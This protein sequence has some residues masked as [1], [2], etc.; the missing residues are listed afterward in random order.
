[1]TNLKIRLSAGVCLLAL[2]LSGCK[3][4][5]ATRIQ[6]NGSGMLRTEV[7]FSAEERRNLEEQNPGD[8]FCNTS[9]AAAGT[10]VTEEQRDGETWCVTEARFADLDELARFYAQRPGVQVNRLEIR[11]GRLYYDV[12]IDTSSDTSSFAGFESIVWTVSLPGQPARHN[13]DQADGATLTW[14]V[15]PRS[16]VVNLHAESPAE[17]ASAGMWLWLALLAAGGLAAAGLWLK[18]RAWRRGRGRAGR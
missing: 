2:L 18:Q 8:D 5:A 17:A 15:A 3:F 4:E 1:M 10:R 16:G 14:Q 13:A 7:G 12:D 11:D 6:G 9:G